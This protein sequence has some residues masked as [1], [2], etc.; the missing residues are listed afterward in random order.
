MDDVEGFEFI[1]DTGGGF[2]SLLCRYAA[3]G[4]LDYLNR[5]LEI[6][7]DVVTDA[8]D[9]KKLFFN[10]MASVLF[11]F[12]G[13]Q[14]AN[15]GLSSPTL[16]AITLKWLADWYTQYHK[17]TDR[18]PWYVRILEI[19]LTELPNDVIR[20]LYALAGIRYIDIG[21]ELVKQDDIRAFSKFQRLEYIFPEQPR[22]TYYQLLAHSNVLISGRDR[23]TYEP[24]LL[25][26]LI[27]Q[28][29]YAPTPNDIIE[30]SNDPY[31]PEIL[32]LIDTLTSATNAGTAGTPALLTAGQAHQGLP[33]TRDEAMALVQAYTN[34][35]IGET[36]PMAKEIARVVARY[37]LGTNTEL[38]RL[39]GP[40]NVQPNDTLWI[41]DDCSNFGGCRMLT[42]CCF[43]GDDGD[44]DS[45]RPSTW[46]TRYCQRPGCYKQIKSLRY[47]KRVALPIG[48]WRGCYCCWEC[49]ETQAPFYNRVIPDEATDVPTREQAIAIIK[50]AGSVVIDCLRIAKGDCYRIGI[51]R[52]PPKWLK[53][54]PAQSTPDV[55]DADFPSVA[56]DLPALE[57]A[58]IQDL[59]LTE[60]PG[61]SYTPLEDVPNEQALA[62]RH[63]G[64]Q[65]LLSG[66]GFMKPDEE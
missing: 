57:E 31:D 5:A 42:C 48:G 18:L 32:T 16:P 13:D 33:Q 14:P 39:L 22:E 45:N 55:V 34:G 11:S 58:F 12:D 66:S 63:I 60:P 44:L 40:V 29:P 35:Y 49:A 19:P 27:P 9:Q 46:F 65:T 37:R 43:E 20:R 26:H 28:M 61:D 59:A 36:I 30:P 38:F 24:L 64:S 52:V 50:S 7:L 15:R 2:G 4:R 10:C 21:L 41:S 53:R 56:S 51:Y 23:E 8:T 54:Q 1:S 6:A 17:S 25:S 47:A 3:A 62:Q